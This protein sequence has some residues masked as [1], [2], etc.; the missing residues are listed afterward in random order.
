MAPSSLHG[1]R[2]EWYTDIWGEHRAGKVKTETDYI[3]SPEVFKASW[4][5]STDGESRWFSIKVKG[6]RQVKYDWV[7]SDRPDHHTNETSDFEITLSF[8]P[9]SSSTDFRMPNGNWY[10]DEEEYKWDWLIDLGNFLDGRQNFND[11]GT[12]KR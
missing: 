6:K 2:T 9:V 5:G 7:D 1:H 12:L 4:G 8:F 10:E 3:Y 11:D